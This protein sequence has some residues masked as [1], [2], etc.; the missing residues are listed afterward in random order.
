[1]QN[2]TK[3]NFQFRPFGIK[4]IYQTHFAISSLFKTCLQE[5]KKQKKVKSTNHQI[6]PKSLICC[7]V[8]LP[9]SAAV[10]HCEAATIS[11]RC[12]LPI[13]CHASKRSG[14]H[15]KKNSYAWILNIG[16]ETGVFS[17]YYTHVGQIV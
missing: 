1:M 2:L 11:T 10:I 13:L 17:Y 8:G 5:E 16:K 7:W 4:P 6:I 14:H 3:I 12:T 15:G 9:S